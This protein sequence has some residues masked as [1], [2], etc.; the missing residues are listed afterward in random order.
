MRENGIVDAPLV[1]SAGDRGRAAEQLGDA[2]SHDPDSLLAN[3]LRTHLV[4]A[5]TAGAY[6]SPEAFTAFIDGG[7]NVA[8]Y[9]R[10]IEQVAT[11]HDLAAPVSVADIGCGDGRVTAAVVSP[12]TTVVDLPIDVCASQPDTRRPTACTRRPGGSG[13]PPPRRRVRRARFR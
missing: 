9:E 6:D 11:I 2:R 3:A 1:I 5:E 8:L 13:Q 10:L 12:S 4:G 7:G